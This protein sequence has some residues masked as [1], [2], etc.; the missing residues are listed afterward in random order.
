MA[1]ELLPLF[2]LAVVLF[3]RTQLPLHI[4]E[5]RDK[6]MMREA[7]RGNSEFGVVLAEE[8]G[9]VNAGCTAIV[10]EVTHR[11]P[12]GRM[13]IMAVGIR[14]FE[15][16]SLDTEKT[17][18]RGAVDY[19][20]DEETEAVSEEVKGQAVE[21]YRALRQLFQDEPP[22]E[23]RWRDPQL[24]FQLAQAVVDLEFRQ[25]LLAT[26]SEAERMRQLVEF[27]P[28]HLERQQDVSHVRAVAPHNG[29][30][31]RPRAS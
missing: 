4:F 2:P 21:D 22:P 18:L 17:Y 24:S 9:V 23:P 16:L 13:D 12:D 27:L 25:R 15:I 8:N 26:R 1:Q 19:F 6:E 20:N 30:G 29:H 31:P 3:P 7:I 5:D 14:R 28:A 10:E 11:Y